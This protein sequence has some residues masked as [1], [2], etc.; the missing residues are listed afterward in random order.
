MNY[1]M[2]YKVMA[3]TLYTY[4]STTVSCWGTYTIG[5]ATRIVSYLRKTAA[6]GRSSYPTDL[7]LEPTEE[8]VYKIWCR[9]YRYDAFVYPMLGTATTIDQAT[10]DIDLMKRTQA[11]SDV[12]ADFWLVEA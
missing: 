5:D 10:A 1:R 3:R 2:N 12:G 4:S 7:W 6:E 9:D 11:A 8:P